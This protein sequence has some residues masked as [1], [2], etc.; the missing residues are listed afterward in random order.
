M[1]PEFL[2]RARRGDHRS[3]KTLTQHFQA[4]ARVDGSR[5]APPDGVTMAEVGDRCCLKGDFATT[6]AQTVREALEQFTRPPAANDG[7]SLGAPG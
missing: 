3:L 5:P 4:C 7:T 6:A 2:D 1:E